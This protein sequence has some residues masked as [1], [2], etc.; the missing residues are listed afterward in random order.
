M[1][2]RDNVELLANVMCLNDATLV[3]SM[4]ENIH[5]D[6]ASTLDNVKCTSLETEPKSVV[7]SLS[8]R[9]LR[10]IVIGINLHLKSLKDCNLV[11]VIMTVVSRDDHVSK[12]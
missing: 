1:N 10:V 3:T 12:I 2:L 5:Y 8:I 9:G 7:I 4:S 11:G 6:A